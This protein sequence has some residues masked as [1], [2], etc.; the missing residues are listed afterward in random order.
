[1]NIKKAVLRGFDEVNCRATVQISGSGKAYL[2][3][4]PV[5]RNLSSSEMI[6]GRNLVVLFFDEHN[7]KDA[8]V[9]TVY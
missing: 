8:V 6:G 4:I 1:M 5:A 3:N 9:M 2:E 7:A